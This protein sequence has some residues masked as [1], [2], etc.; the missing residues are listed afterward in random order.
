MRDS[1]VFAQVKSLK[2]KRQTAR[3]SASA[4]EIHVRA[5]V[6][7]SGTTF[8]AFVAD[9][10]LN[11]IAPGS[12]TTMAALELCL[13]GLWYRANDGYIIADPDLVE[14]LAQPASR[15]WLRAVGR[16]LKEYLSPL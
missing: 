14:R 9:M 13:A 12:V 7:S 6:D 16:F 8:P 4:L 15:R 3:L 11:A 5:A 1:V 2:R 10:R